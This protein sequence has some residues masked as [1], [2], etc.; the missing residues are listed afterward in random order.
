MLFLKYGGFF[1]WGQSMLGKRKTSNAEM[2]LRR[3]L[4]HSGVLWSPLWEN[5]RMDEAVHK[6]WC[7]PPCSTKSSHL[8]DSA[9][10]GR[11]KE[12]P[13][14]PGL[15]FWG[16]KL[17]H[18]SQE[19]FLQVSEF[20]QVLANPQESRQDLFRKEE[21]ALVWAEATLSLQAV[22]HSKVKN[23]LFLENWTY[24]SCFPTSKL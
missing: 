4:L 20:P 13:Q 8:L 14:I 19:Q 1:P 11:G 6:E 17:F 10:W 16:T 22:L 23:N 24:F 2:L 12:M 3:K 5:C 21:S 18:Q 9:L 15:V 7:Q